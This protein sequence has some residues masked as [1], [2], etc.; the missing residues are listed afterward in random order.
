[1]TDWSAKADWGIGA[2]GIGV[3]IH[4]AGDCRMLW[5]E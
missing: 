5:E 3:A 4:A 1:M 2:E